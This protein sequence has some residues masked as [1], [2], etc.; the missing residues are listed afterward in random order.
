[1]GWVSA[2]SDGSDG[3][4]A[5]VR[6][7]AG[8]GG[9]AGV[10]FRG[11]MRRVR[12]K[13]TVADSGRPQPPPPCRPPWVDGHSYSASLSFRDPNLSHHF[14]PAP[15]AVTS[16]A[17]EKSC[18]GIV[19]AR[20]T[21]GSLPRFTIP[22][23]SPSGVRTISPAQINSS[24]SL[25]SNRA[26]SPRSTIQICSERAWTWRSETALGSMVTCVIV[27]RLSGELLGQT[28]CLD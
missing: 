6:R 9:I 10:Q 5:T 1:M 24:C 4:R 19:T 26:P 12:P 21:S 28:N 15:E 16:Y 17:E 27:A 3:R 23:T 22:W 11:P 18:G 14:A 13:P 7:T 20:Y 8:T 25:L 2:R